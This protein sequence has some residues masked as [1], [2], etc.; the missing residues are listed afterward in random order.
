MT[1]VAVSCFFSS[2]ASLLD[3]WVNGDSEMP[4]LSSEVT[5]PAHGRVRAMCIVPSLGL[6]KLPL[7][8]CRDSLDIGAND[9]PGTRVLNGGGGHLGYCQ[10]G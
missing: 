8:A 6:K 2:A 9:H 7:S 4:S 10:W 1:L 5:R 3:S